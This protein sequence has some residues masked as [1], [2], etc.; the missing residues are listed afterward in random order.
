[1]SHFTYHIFIYHD[2]INTHK[3]IHFKYIKHRAAES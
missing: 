3:H 2:P 1:M